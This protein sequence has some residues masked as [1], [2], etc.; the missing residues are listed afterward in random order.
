MIY[1][2][3]LN[4]NNYVGRQKVIYVGWDWGV[5]LDISIAGTGR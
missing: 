3:K 1:R 4:I 2:N 5:G